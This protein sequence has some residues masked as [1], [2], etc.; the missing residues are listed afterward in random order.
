MRPGEILALQWK[1]SADDHVEVVHRLYRGKL[2]VLCFGS[3]RGLWSGSNVI[4]I[5]KV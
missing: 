4:L 1:H 3:D 5:Y 2:D